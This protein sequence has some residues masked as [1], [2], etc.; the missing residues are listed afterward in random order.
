MIQGM[1]RPR[2][3]M[4]PTSSSRLKQ[5]AESVASTMVMASPTLMAL[6]RK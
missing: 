3:V 4:M 1:T 5:R 2:A 6:M